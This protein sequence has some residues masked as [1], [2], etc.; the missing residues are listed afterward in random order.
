MFSEEKMRNPTCLA[1]LALFLFAGCSSG[2]L[3]GLPEK[4]G[5]IVFEANLSVDFFGG[6]N[7][8]MTDIVL[9]KP[10]KS[11]PMK[12]ET[13]DRYVVFQNLEPGNY[14]L[15]RIA[16]RLESAGDTQSFTV[17]FRNKR[18]YV[19][20]GTLIYFGKYVVTISRK[21]GG[22]QMKS[23]LVRNPD[24]EIRAWTKILAANKKSP[25]REPIEKRLREIRK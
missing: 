14:E 5:V 4:T 6:G 7:F 18:F 9:I 21:W 23:K 15:K 22:R 13:F 11:E 10:G 19:W 20:P 24:D 1:L 8:P 25:W 17:S 2:K 3:T 12:G 16:E